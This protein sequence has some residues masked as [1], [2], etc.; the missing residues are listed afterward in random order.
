[1]H[2]KWRASKMASRRARAAAKVQPS[3]QGGSVE[4]RNEDGGDRVEIVDECVLIS[5]MI[6]IPDFA[7]AVVPSGPLNLAC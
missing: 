6:P 2:P 4:A 3:F 1:M 5:S 7:Q